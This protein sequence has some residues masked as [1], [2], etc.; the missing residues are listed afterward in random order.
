MIPVIFGNHLYNEDRD[1]WGLSRKEPY[2]QW[3]ATIIGEHPE[4]GGQRPAL[5]WAVKD[6]GP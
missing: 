2:P 1:S 4:H 3:I 6:A 5:G